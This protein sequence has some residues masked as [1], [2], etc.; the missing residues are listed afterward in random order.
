LAQLA[1]KIAGLRD[2]DKE[3]LAEQLT[4]EAEGFRPTPRQAGPT[5][6]E[7]AMNLVN[8]FALPV[9]KA[10]TPAERLHAVVDEREAIKLATEALEQRETQQR[11]VALN[12]MMD[13]GAADWRK[14]VRRR[15]MALLELRAANREAALFRGELQR[16]AKL[17]VSLVCDS[18]AAPLFGPPVVGDQAY[19]FLQMC[20]KHGIVSASE[21]EN[22]V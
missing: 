5:I 8:G 13:E 12:A 20:I 9:D 6:R 4:L 14:I 1:K 22:A 21:I 16:R 15:V 3:L 10:P 18:N 2:R 17:T 7:R 11:V 19:V